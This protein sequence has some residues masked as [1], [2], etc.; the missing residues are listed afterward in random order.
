MNN[1]LYK[2][3]AAIMIILGLAIIG[4]GVYKII[5]DNDQNDD[6]IDNLPIVDA[7][8]TNEE[9][10][11]IVLNKYNELLSFM[12]SQTGFGGINTDEV[13]EFDLGNNNK[14]LYYYAPNF[15]EEFNKIFV[16]DIKYNMV[17][18]EVD[19]INKYITFYGVDNGDNY[20]SYI[21]D[22]EK[23]Y[24]NNVCLGEMDYLDIDIQNGELSFSDNYDEIIYIVDVHD[25][26]NDYSL[27]R[28]VDLILKQE[29]NEW[30]FLSA[31]THGNYDRVL[32]I[33]QDN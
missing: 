17:F 27:V 29:N 14:S 8:I 23:Y 21:L 32:Y 5:F 6:N 30:K 26:N 2:I 31:V 25:V 10:K 16:S 15:V 13:L 4:F 12:N 1:K 19:N 33:N 3:L 20:Y 9:A 18:G 22:D 28:K 24:V 11:T 7:P